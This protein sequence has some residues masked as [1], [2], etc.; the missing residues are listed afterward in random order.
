MEHVSFDLTV[1]LGDLLVLAGFIFG[2]ITFMFSIRQDVT[3]LKETE[4]QNAKKIQELKTS[5]DALSEATVTLARQDERMKA[6]DHRLNKLED[7]M[8]ANRFHEN[9][10]AV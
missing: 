6:F 2:G 3:S 1:K 8:H 7:A 5:V 9:L 10:Q 4:N